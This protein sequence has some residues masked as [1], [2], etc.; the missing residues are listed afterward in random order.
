MNLLYCIRGQ[1]HNLIKDY[2]NN[3]TQRVM[4]VKIMSEDLIVEYGV[5]QGSIVGLLLFLTYIN[6]FLMVLHGA[7][8]PDLYCTFILINI[9]PYVNVC[10]SVAVLL[11]IF[12]KNILILVY[13]L[14]FVPTEDCYISDRVCFSPRP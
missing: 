4:V 10:V 7:F 3:W 11:R 5:P 8:S 13:F 1:P 14:Q 6:D 12:P 2:L 9:I